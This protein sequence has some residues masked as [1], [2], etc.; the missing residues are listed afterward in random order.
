MRRPGLTTI[1]AAP[2]P[3]MTMTRG[4]IGGINGLRLW[5][6]MMALDS[7]ET[8]AGTVTSIRNLVSGVAI[9]TAA[10]NLPLF[11]PVGCNGRPCMRG[12]IGTPR[13]L[14]GTEAAVV[15]VAAGTDLPQTIMMVTQPSSAAP[16]G[17]QENFAWANSGIAVNNAQYA[18]RAITTGRFRYEVV[19]D[20]AANVAVTRTAAVTTVP[21]VV[22]F[23]TSG[24][25]GSIFVNREGIANPNGGALNVG[26]ITPNRFALFCVPDSSPD[27]FSDDTL[28]EL[29][30][31]SGF[32]GDGVRVKL[33]EYLMAKWG[34]A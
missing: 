11:E 26:A 20:A 15:A 9:S 12:G 7:Y 31:F 1:R 10:T 18:G 23:R 30:V 8:S 16:A 14:I 6:D 29:L 4:T 19:D 28:A 17:Y 32:V 25:A 21:Q 5:L 34:I 33:T 22:C 3:G 2:N 27:T 13:G 24:I